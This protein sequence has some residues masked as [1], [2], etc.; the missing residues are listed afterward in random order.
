MR[1]SFRPAYLLLLALLLTATAAC[2]NPTGPT[3]PND[4]YSTSGN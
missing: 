3:Q 4:N 2:T 1:T